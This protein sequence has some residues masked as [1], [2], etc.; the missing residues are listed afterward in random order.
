MVKDELHRILEILEP[1]W[2]HVLDG[3][4]ARLA[5]LDQLIEVLSREILDLKPQLPRY[6]QLLFLQLLMGF[7]FMRERGKGLILTCIALL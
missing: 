6:R 2:V 5:L 3:L 4:V 7:S 1:H